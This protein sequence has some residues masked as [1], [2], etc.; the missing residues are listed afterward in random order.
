MLRRVCIA[1]GEGGY[2]HGVI[3]IYVRCSISKFMRKKSSWS[4]KKSFDKLCE[5]NIKTVVEEH[6]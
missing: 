3:F 2:I 5:S 1:K 4:G 6:I